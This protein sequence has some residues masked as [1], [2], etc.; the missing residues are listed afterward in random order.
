MEDSYKSA[1]EVAK[2]FNTNVTLIKNICDLM[3]EDILNFVRRNNLNHRQLSDH[4]ITV[5]AA[6]IGL[7]NF[8]KLEDAVNFVK[9]ELYGINR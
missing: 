9:K 7:T 8:M 1:P 3:A 5:I 4:N 6:V 2:Q